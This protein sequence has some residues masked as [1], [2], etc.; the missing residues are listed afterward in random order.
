M[1]L[2]SVSCLLLVAVLYPA[3]ASAPCYDNQEATYKAQFDPTDCNAEC[4]VTPFFSPDHS[5]TAY[6]EVIKAAEE[7]IDLLEPG[8]RAGK[9]FF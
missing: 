6:V 9:A 7:S 4:T 3:S 5:V 8:N 1:M 2:L